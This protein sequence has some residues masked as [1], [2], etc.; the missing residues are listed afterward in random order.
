MGGWVTPERKLYFLPV[1]SQVSPPIPK[2]ER[3]L[4]LRLLPVVWLRPRRPD[5]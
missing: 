3:K 4:S 2:K 5:G 1:T